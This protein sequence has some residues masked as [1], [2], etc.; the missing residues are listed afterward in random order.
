MSAFVGL[1]Y[2][3]INWTNKVFN[4]IQY[5][6]VSSQ[7]GKHFIINSNAN[8]LR[9]SMLDGSPSGV[10]ANVA[11]EFEQQSRFAQSTG[12]VE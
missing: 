1:F 6:N 11:R 12:V 9:V 2:A 5:K 4:Y 10:M 7:T 3:E 8:V